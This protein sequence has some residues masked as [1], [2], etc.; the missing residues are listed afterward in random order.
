[1]AA[2]AELVEYPHRWQTATER[3]ICQSWLPSMGSADL[4]EPQSVG[5]DRRIVLPPVVRGGRQPWRSAYD[6]PAMH[7][8]VE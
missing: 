4:T 3:R 8:P 5:L 7:A 2:T 6:P 1:M